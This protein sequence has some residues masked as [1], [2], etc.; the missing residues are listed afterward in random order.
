MFLQEGTV[1]EKSLFQSLYNIG[2][3]CTVPTQ[4]A[5]GR[6]FIYVFCKI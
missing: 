2:L 5:V 3:C 4:A 1:T 6:R